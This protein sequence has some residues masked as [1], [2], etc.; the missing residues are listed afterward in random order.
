MRAQFTI[1]KEWWARALGL[2]VIG[3]LATF[4]GSLASPPLLIYALAITAA[5][6]T[7][8][9]FFAQLLFDRDHSLGER[10]RRRIIV[11]DG[12]DQPI[13]PAVEANL[14]AEFGGRA[15]KIAATR[16]I[17][18]ARRRGQ[19]SR[20]NRGQLPRA[21]KTGELGRR[22]VMLRHGAGSYQPSSAPL[23]AFA[24]LAIDARRGEPEHRCSCL[25]W[26]LR[27]SRNA[28]RNS[29]VIPASVAWS[30]SPVGDTAPGHPGRRPAW[31]LRRPRLIPATDVRPACDRA[32][33]GSRPATGVQPSCDR[34]MASSALASLR[35]LAGNPRRRR[36]LGG[37]RNGCSASLRRLPAS[38]RRLPGVSPASLAG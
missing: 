2:R 29:R 11:A 10:V 23:G 34:R 32:A 25:A 1:A 16:P 5:V 15:K 6:A 18:P 27:R 30:L 20:E 22:Q 33:T 38:P 35:R 4:A 17:D 13:P 8:G 14:R 12:L 21:T 37:P 26:P 31:Q 7:A 24:A 19:L 28:R 9:A 36:D 3:G